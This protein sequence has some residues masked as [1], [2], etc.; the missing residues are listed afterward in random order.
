MV[1][2][3]KWRRCRGGQRCGSGRSTDGLLGAYNLGVATPRTLVYTGDKTSSDARSWYMFSWDAKSWVVIVCFDKDTKS[4]LEEAPSEAKESHLLGS[5][6]PLISEEFEAFEQSGTRTISSYSSASSDST[7]LLSPDHPLTHVSPTP[8]PTR[9]SF[10]RR[11][12][13]MTVCAQPAMSLGHLARVTEMMALSDSSFYKRYRSSYETLLT[14]P[15]LTLPV[16]KRYRGTSKLIEDTEG[17]SS[18]LDSEREGSE[19]ESSDSDDERESQ[20]R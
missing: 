14:S 19:D 2:L 15:S 18:E 1:Q 5:K 20:F 7:A 6:A 12:T 17:E 3:L 13:R 8:T 9:A 4:E 16:R 11:T 10:Y